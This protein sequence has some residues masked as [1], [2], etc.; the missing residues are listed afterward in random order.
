MVRRLFCWML[1]GLRG[2]LLAVALGALFGWAWSWR[3]PGF[4]GAERHYLQPDRV[5]RRDFA[6][7]WTNGRI[8]VGRWWWTFSNGLVDF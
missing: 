3:Y 2:L 6:A 4:I 1:W 7:G 8:A 5:D